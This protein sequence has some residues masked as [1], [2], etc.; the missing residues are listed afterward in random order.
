MIKQN[1]DIGL[2]IL[3]IAVGGMMLL[4]GIHKIGS[5]LT[6]IEELVTKL[7]LPAFTSYGVYLGEVVAPVL[8]IIGFKTRLSS[9]FF[10]LTCL[11]IIFVA[12]PSDIFKLNDY[13]GWQLELVGLYAFGGLALIFTGGGKFVVKD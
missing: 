11:F 4:H 13:G 2:L 6:F 8:M 7:G 3:R 9:L 12:H 5:D 1:T 10:F